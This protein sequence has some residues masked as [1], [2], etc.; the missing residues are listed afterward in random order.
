MSLVS[1]VIPCYNQARFL[2]QAI[3]SALAQ[4]HKD[5]E[6]IVVNDGSTDNTAE[7]A[8]RYS[9]DPRV[10]LINQKNAGLP[11]AR[12]SARLLVSPGL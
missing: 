8:G 4:T 7:V 5:V 6:V 11:A 1:I 3:E 12:N 2:G 10:R 9:S